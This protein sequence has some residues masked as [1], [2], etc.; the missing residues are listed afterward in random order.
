MIADDNGYE[1]HAIYELERLGYGLSPV[2]TNLSEASA[3]LQNWSP[4]VVLADLHFPSTAEGTRLL[5]LSLSTDSVRL[6]IAI[7]H[8]RPDTLPP[9][10]ADCCGADSYQDAERIHKVIWHRARGEGLSGDDRV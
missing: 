10:V 8:A 3:L 1:P 2:A 4:H 6:V 5:S 9:G 7:S